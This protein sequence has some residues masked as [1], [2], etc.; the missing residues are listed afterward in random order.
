VTRLYLI[1]A[2]ALVSPIASAGTP[3][4]VPFKAANVTVSFPKGWIVQQ[5]NGVFAA[6]QDPKQKDAAG[7]LFMDIPN[8]TNATE[9]QLLDTVGA[10]VAKDLEVAD[11]A[12]IKGGTGHYMIANGT[13]DGV[14][15]RIA[16]IAAIING[17]AIVS[18]FVAKT[19]DFDALGGLSLALQVLSSLKPDAP[20]AVA[21]PGG[22]LVVGA[23]S[24]PLTVADLAGDWTQDDSAVTSYSSS[25]TSS[26]GYSAAATSA[27]WRIDPKGIIYTQLTATTSGGGGG[28]YQVN[29]KSA[30]TITVTA[31]G[32]LSITH[33]KGEGVSPTYLI[34]GWGATSDVT[35]LKLNGPYYGAIEDRVRKDPGY[36]TNLDGYWVRQNPKPAK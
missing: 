27:K 34:R 32:T 33:K 35:V 18:V 25:S 28:T 29:Q 13:S 11:R 2:L 8:A 14:K 21:A 5:E 16:A 22:K 23:P 17:Q 24:R 31:D 4:L 3:T 30:G 6:Q 10:Q 12:A 19:S 26:G 36:A 1:L 15:V 9:D 20:A 7:I